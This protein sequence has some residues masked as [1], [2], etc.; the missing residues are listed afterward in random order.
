MKSVLNIYLEAQGDYD[1]VQIIFL[2]TGGW[3]SE[4][5]LG[6]TSILLKSDTAI[7][8]DA[9]EGVYRA[10]RCCGYSIENIDAI[11]LTHKHGDHI[12]G[13]PTL[14]LM[15]VHK[16][17]N[18]IKIITHRDVKEAIHKLF[19]VIGVEY[20]IKSIEFIEIAPGD[21]IRYN[22][23]DIEIFE[24]FHTVPAISMRFEVEGKCI[25]FSGDTRYNPLLAELAKDC[26]VLIHEVSNY[27]VD[28]YTY[29]HSNYLEAMDIAKK[30]GVKMFIPIHFY[31]SPLPIDTMYL[32][33]KSKIYMPMPCMKLE[34]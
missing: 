25:T 32:P 21:K 15:A 10:L 31:Q 27:D 19:N 17:I 4:P 3:I 22:N 30:A 26:D 24:A 7:L 12:L 34:V 16:G 14:V 20:L 2:G 6:Y 23:F 33:Y 5:F 29:G 1:M 28:A 18:Q 8:I 11:I 13:L 9:G